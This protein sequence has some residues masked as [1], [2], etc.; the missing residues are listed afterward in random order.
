M[1]EDVH[2]EVLDVFY[3][4]NLALEALNRRTKLN[5]AVYMRGTK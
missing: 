1:L 3:L 2:N 5:G 4:Y